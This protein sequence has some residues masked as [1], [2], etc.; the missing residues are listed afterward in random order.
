MNTDGLARHYGS[1]TR[2]ERL[3]LM[4]A[5]W[6]RGDAVEFDRLA[7]SA[8]RSK[9]R[10]ADFVGLFLELCDLAKEYVLK[11]L[12]TAVVYWRLKDYLDQQP[13]GGGRRRGRSQAKEHRRTLRLLA[14]FC[15]LRADGW[16]L[17]C[18]G[19]LI[20]PDVP[21]RKLPGYKA[22]QEMEQDARVLAFTAEEAAAYLREDWKAAPPAEEKAPPAGGRIADAADVAWAMRKK[23]E[24][25]LEAWG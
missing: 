8:P 9:A 13:V 11:Q 5:A 22:V 21:P 10:I 24:A 23:F 1:L 15:V 16:K 18:E 7:R 17:F 2:W 14:F 20:D 19:L 25:R 6:A 3:P 12:D 4:A